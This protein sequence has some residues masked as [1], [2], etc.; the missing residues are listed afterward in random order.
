[1]GK[2]IKS[3]YFG[4]RNYPYDNENVGGNS[5][6]GGEGVATITK[7]NTGTYYTTSTT[8]ALSFTAP[9]IT[10][11]VA[12]TGSVTTNAAGNVATVTLLTA[13]KGYT[14]A[15]TA[16]VVGGTTGTVATF[17]VTLF[18]STVTQ[19]AISFSSRLLAKD[20]GGSTVTNGDIQKQESSRRYLVKDSN[21]Q[22]QV[23]LVGRAI[24]NPGEMT[25]IATDEGGATYY[26]TKLTAHRATLVYI[27]GT[28]IY[29]DN[30]AVGWS[31]TSPAPAGTVTIA[32]K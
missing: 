5:G 26:V 32:S 23:K 18:A 17:N 24:A 7:N 29:D 19:N 30:T 3:L 13:G 11:G 14:G 6:T 10:G 27:T 20:G 25:I 1:M 9:Q 28:Q 15:P 16:T 4:N 12:P 21:G 22:G 2:P 8:L 31:F